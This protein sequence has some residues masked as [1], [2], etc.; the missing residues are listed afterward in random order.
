MERLIFGFL[1]GVSGDRGIGELVWLWVG[2]FIG[3]SGWVW[4]GV[5]VIWV[6]WGELR[7]IRSGEVMCVEI[8]GLDFFFF[9]EF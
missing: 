7:S 3:Y 1:R 9:M 6:G 2:D 4:W 8:K 5:E